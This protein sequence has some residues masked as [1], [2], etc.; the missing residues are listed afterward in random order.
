[1]DVKAGFRLKSFEMAAGVFSGR[2]GEEDFGSGKCTSNTAV[3]VV[4]AG[5]QYRQGC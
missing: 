4:L 5:L 3:G 2:D 1:M